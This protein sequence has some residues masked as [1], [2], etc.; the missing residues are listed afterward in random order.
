MVVTM[1]FRVT[2]GMNEFFDK[3]D[4]KES[5]CEEDFSKRKMLLAIWPYVSS[6]KSF[7]DLKNNAFQIKRLISLLKRLK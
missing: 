6:F 3:V 5:N 1:Q 7:T 2:G 4:E